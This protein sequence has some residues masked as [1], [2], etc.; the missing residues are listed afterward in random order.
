MA[1]VDTALRRVLELKAMFGLLPE[2]GADTAAIAMPSADAIAQATADGRE[3]AKRMAREAIT[4]INDGQS[5]ATLDDIRSV[6]ADACRPC[7]CRRPVRRR[8]RLLPG[9]LHRPSARR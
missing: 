4:L 8:F 5:A 2:D 9:R 1:A 3:Q 6:I 7:D